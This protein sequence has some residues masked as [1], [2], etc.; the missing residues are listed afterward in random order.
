MGVSS[1]FRSPA[2]LD[3]NNSV[4]VAPVHFLFCYIKPE[5]ESFRSRV[6][7]SKSS[8]NWPRNESFCVIVSEV[9]WLSLKWYGGENVYNRDRQRPDSLANTDRRRSL[10]RKKAKQLPCP[11]RLSESCL[12]VINTIFSQ[13]FSIDVRFWKPS[14]V[15]SA[16]RGASGARFACVRR[17]PSGGGGPSALLAWFFLQWKE[18]P[19]H[20]VGW[21]AYHRFLQVCSWVAR[22]VLR[23]GL[24]NTV[25]SERGRL[26]RAVA[27]PCALDQLHCTC[28][29]SLAND[30]SWRSLHRWNPTLCCGR[31]AKIF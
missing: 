20:F 11:G 16:R 19:L 8:K 15:N 28:F 10:N 17:A 14:A 30:A 13:C 24:E 5:V 12:C 9:G 31:K 4:T 1:L 27:L 23:Q 25:Y 6:R 18:S 22:M 26:R 2:T 29:R 3:R 7:L 21:D